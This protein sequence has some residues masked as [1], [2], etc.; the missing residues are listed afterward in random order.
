MKQSMLL[1]CK[2]YISESRNEA[3]LDLMERAARRDGETVI[4][5]K[6]KDD[7]YNRV[8]YNLVSYV[9]HDSLGCP[10]YTPLHQSVV[11]M[12]EAAYG[13]INLESHS[14]AHP[15]LGVVDDI[16][17]HPLARASL[18]EAAWLARAI[19]SDIGSRFQGASFFYLIESC[20]MQAAFYDLLTSLN[21]EIMSKC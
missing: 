20:V 14:G 13:A 18:D 17:C 9:V 12:A 21:L 4:V 3:A 16:A 10:I 15:R 2:V 6:F 19:A 11:A 7:D 1:C 5:N 8:R